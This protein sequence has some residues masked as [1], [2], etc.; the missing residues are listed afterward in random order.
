MDFEEGSFEINPSFRAILRSDIVRRHDMPQKTFSSME[1]TM[2][3]IGRLGRP[4][5][6]GISGTPEHKSHANA[7]KSNFSFS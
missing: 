7:K 5:D 1:K 6:C 4:F 2:S 3:W